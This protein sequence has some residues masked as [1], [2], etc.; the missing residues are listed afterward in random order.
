[1]SSHYKS[2]LLVIVV[3]ALAFWLARPAF[4]RFMSDEAFVRRRNLWLSLTLS[5]FLIP[6]FWLYMGVA[7]VL[8]WRAARRDPNPAA[9]YLF[10]LLVVPPFQAAIPGFGLGTFLFQMDHFRLL[11]LALVL[12][13]ALRMSRAM[14]K[15]GNASV[16]RS[17]LAPDVFIVIYGLLPVILSMRYT[18][19]SDSMRSVLLLGIDLLLPYYVLS[20][21]CTSKPMLVEAIAAF[22][23]SAVILAPLALIESAKA[24]LLYSSISDHWRL[25]SNFIGYLFRGDIL[26]AQ[27]TSGQ[28]IILGNFYAVGLG[29]WLY[30]QY[31]LTGWRRWLGTAAMVGGLFAALSRGPWVGAAVCG[32]AFFA[33]GPNATTRVLKLVGVSAVVVA[34]VLASPMGA[35]IVDHLP[36]IGTVDAGNVTYRQAMIDRSWLVI[37]QNPLFGSPYFLSYMEDLRTGEGIIDLLNAYLTIGMAY[38]LVTLAALLLFFT[39]VAFKC[40]QVTRINALRDPDTSRLGAALFASLSGAMVIL[41]TVSNYLSVPYIYIGLTALM[42]A[43]SRIPTFVPEPEVQA[44]LPVARVDRRWSTSIRP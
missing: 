37:Q 29:L 17:W 4:A 28:S 41:Y 3:T 35:T 34:V 11:T 21:S 2:F 10:L 40:L 7:A 9:L 19:V 31:G 42:V 6:S 33:V 44:G 18:S 27:V 32:F 16:R 30:L 23:L 14:K 13:A 25:S 8:I 1:M 36:F 5:A 22:A 26:R 39:T 38:G 15:A 43:Y 20:R 12:P 24:W